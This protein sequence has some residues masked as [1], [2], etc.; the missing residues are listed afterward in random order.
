MLRRL[1]LTLCS[2]VLTFGWLAPVLTAPARAA[3][4]DSRPLNL[5]TSPLPISLNTEPGKT[6]STDLRVKQNGGA[7]ERLKVSLMKFTAFGEE[8]KPR[9]V[10]R[11]PGD[12]YFDWVRFDKTS[13][14]APNNVWQTVKMTINVPK[15]NAAFGYYYAAVFSRVG[16]D[17]KLGPR[18]NAIAGGTAVL[19]LLDVKVAG[20]HRAVDLERFQVE[21]GVYEFLPA[22]FS[23]KFKNTGNVH[24]V[25]HGNIFITKGNKQVGMLEVNLEQGN[26]LPESKRVYPSEWLDGFPHYEPVV[27]DGKVKLDGK[28]KQMRKLVWSN[29]RPGEKDLVPHLRMG[30]Y[31]AHLFAVYDDG[32]RDVAL[33]AEVS[34]WVI[35]WRGLLIVL[36][37]ILLVV[38]GIVATT[39][40]AWRRLRG[41]RGRK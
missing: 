26:L 38:F 5:T 14:D 21:R 34:F 40:G 30:K 39:R 25:P 32:E 2:F 23:T 16:D 20:A 24:V 19:V 4:G 10:D 18:T 11:E 8:G 3:D 37:V 35:P 1:A 33:E 41:L 29:G 17:V 12:S 36:V 15:A 6:V 27:E 9:L 31:T 22:K 13:F 28:G 7:T